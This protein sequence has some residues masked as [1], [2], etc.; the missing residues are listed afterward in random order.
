MQSGQTPILF[1]RT[2]QLG[3]EIHMIRDRV[4]SFFTPH[5]FFF[6]KKYNVLYIRNTYNYVK[7][8]QHDRYKEVS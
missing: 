7:T 5:H 2:N 1:N 4:C 3:N 6:M 8:A